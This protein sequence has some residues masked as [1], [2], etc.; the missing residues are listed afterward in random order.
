[1]GQLLFYTNHEQRSLRLGLPLF[2]PAGCL[3]YMLP[4]AGPSVLRRRHH[5]FPAHPHKGCALPS[6]ATQ[7]MQVLWGWEEGSRKRKGDWYS[8]FSGPQS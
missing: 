2:V 1:M 5:L 8:K 7:G 3:S 6:Q 4:P